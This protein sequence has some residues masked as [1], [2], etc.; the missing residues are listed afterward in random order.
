[1]NLKHRFTF[2]LICLLLAGA[3]I[4]SAA[5]DAYLGWNERGKLFTR[6]VELVESTMLTVPGLVRAA[7]PVLENCKQA[8]LN[9]EPTGDRDPGLIYN[10]LTNL[11][12]YLALADALPKPYPFPA[13]A[14]KQ[15]T[16]LR[17]VVTR[18]NSHFRATLRLLE[19]QVRNPDRD[20]LARYAEANLKVGRPDPAKP[21]VVFLGD[22]ITDSWRLNEYFPGRDFLNRGISGQITG[23][24]LGR[25]MA[26]VI[27]LKPV[28][29]LIL[30]G[31]ND[32]ARKVPLSA[33]ENNLTMIVE[34]A[35]LHH[36]KVI[37]ASVTPVNNYNK[38]RDPR[39]EQTLR[40]PA[41]TILALNDWI[42]SYCRR[43]RI[44]YLNYFSHMVDANGF[45]QK[46]LS[47]EG[48][49]PNAAGYRRMAPLALQAIDK[50][51]G[52]RARK[53]RR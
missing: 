4:S 5:P 50:V 10:L 30:A 52:R 1:M 12:A 49:H 24:M 20:N 8:R 51:V 40:R 53:R 35:R 22:S 34:L 7:A 29:V 36:I 37:L 11:R 47:D 14:S 31:T 23:Q 39:L 38:D 33:I 28:A 18:I 16:E 2:V 21:R 6:S 32:I 42:R 3:S 9:L 27:D 19:A 48:L 26:D 43:N 25:M 15:F 44:D 17:D 45:L 41:G 46:D 13:E